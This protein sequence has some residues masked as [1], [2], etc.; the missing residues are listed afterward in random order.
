[1][2]IPIPDRFADWLIAKAKRNPY[3][4]LEGYMNRYW[5]I[6]Y[7]Q[8][9]DH[10]YGIGCYIAKW[11]RNPFV[12]LCQQFDVAARVHEIL[13]D[14]NADA[15]HDHPWSYL[16]VILKEGYVEVKPVFYNGIYNGER[17]TFVPPGSV[18][19][20]RAED[21]HRL[22]V[23][24]PSRPA[25]TLFITFRYRQKW[26]FLTTPNAKTYYRDYFANHS[27]RPQ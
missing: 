4:H 23:M 17:A 19:F 18:L 9:G 8:Q 6:P 2:R 1:M 13:R 3:F 11:W 15:H 20:R 24:S 12:W 5:L 10:E 14:D 26:G 16:T 25:V 27:E 22:E 21:W 7:R